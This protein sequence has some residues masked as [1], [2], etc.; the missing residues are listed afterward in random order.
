MYNIAKVAKGEMLVYFNDVFDAL[1]KLTADTEMT[2]KNGSELLDRL[3]KDIVS[4]SAANYAS[5]TIP[6]TAEDSVPSKAFSLPKFI[7]L[8]QERILVLNPFTRMFLVSWIT[9]LDSVPDLELVAYLPDFLGGLLKFLSDPNHDVY[10]STKGALE[11]F[12]SEIKKIAAVKKG[13]AESRKSRGRRQVSD[14]STALG[15]DSPDATETSAPATPGEEELGDMDSLQGVK[16]EDFDDEWI[17]GQDVLI[18]H[19]RIM[20]TIVTFLS[21]SKEQEVQIMALMWI[22]AFLDI[23]PE[24]MLVF[25]PRLLAQ[26]LPALSHGNESVKQAAQR[27]NKAL[28]RYIM[29]LPEDQPAPDARQTL[30]RT[31]SNLQQHSRA[32]SQTNGEIKREVLPIRTSRKAET[33]EPSSPR[34]EPEQAAE[35]TQAYESFDYEGCVS[36]LTLQFLHEHEATRVAAL[37]WLIMLHRKSPRKIHAIHDV[38]FPALLKTLSDPSDAVVTRDLLLLSQLSKSSED[39]YF[40]PFMANLLKLFTTDRRLLE[41]RG[42][43]IIRQLCLSLSPEKIYR[44]MADCLEKDADEDIEFASIMVQN[45]NNNLITAPELQDLRKRL[46]NLDGRDGQTFFT[47]LFKAWCVNAVA[48]FSLCLLAQA[49]EQAYNLLQ[50]FADM[51]MTV[52]MLIQIDKLVQLLESPVFT[53][54]RMQLLEMERF[55]YLHKCLYGLLM[56]LPQ[57][58]A[59]A[60]LK[61]RLNSVSAAAY[62]YPSAARVPLATPTVST[63]E[64]QNR[65]RGKE[66]QVETGIRWTELLDKF[67][68]TQE[69]VR[70]S[71]QRLLT[72]REASPDVEQMPPVKTQP[73]QEQQPTAASVAAARPGIGHT[74]AKSSL[75]N[76]GRFTT[77][78][79]GKK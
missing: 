29:A 67:R 65:L 42:N 46:R 18:D 61:N 5:M 12:L 26:L 25:T 9:L 41:S 56:L 43:L 47:I 74:K 19:V 7:P 71:Q 38:T 23:C 77:Q 24:E 76:L 68:L 48:T 2:V 31:A 10:T 70:R 45:L 16:V 44:T 69:R 55:P 28:M 35:N 27:V 79:K 54:L 8:L 72:G 53:Y 6:D 36:A 11:N 17:P 22:E 39:S 50:I 66:G 62:L 3:I 1:A 15:F 4:E 37:A 13:I 30:P 32:N 78:R 33:S 63:F 21:E 64:R 34:L 14:S 58:S 75:G 57:S 40:T 20:D 49:Y 52:N 51:E 60:A 73:Q 59:F